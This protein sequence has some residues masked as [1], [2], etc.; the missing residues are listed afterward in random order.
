MDLVYLLVGIVVGVLIGW[1]LKAFFSE[2]GNP[3][4]VAE[5]TVQ[6][7]IY[8]TLY[9]DYQKLQATLDAKNQQCEE[10]S[11][12]LAVSEQTVEHYNEKLKTQQT[13][14]LRSQDLL[15]SELENLAN[16]L[17]EEKSVRFSEHNIHSINNLLS[18]MR[19]RFSLFESRLE[20]VHKEES[21]QRIRL[22][23]QVR[24]LAELNQQMSDDAQKLVNA[25]KGNT[26]IQ[27][28]WG[29]LVLEKVLEK[30][31]LS[32]GREYEV[33]DVHQNTE[34]NRHIPDVIIYLPENKHLII[35]SKVSLVA[36]ERFVS[37]DDDASRR[38]ALR[39]H[40][41]SLKNHIK[42]LSSKQYASLNS[43][44][45][46]DFVMLFVPIESAL[47]IALEADSELLYE[48]FKMNVILVTPSTLMATARTVSGLWKQVQQNLNAREIARL[49]GELYDHIVEFA[50]ELEQVGAKLKQ[51][52]K[53]YE[54]AVKKLQTG[55][56]SLMSGAKRLE[57]LGVS[58]QKTI[59]FHLDQIEDSDLS[60]N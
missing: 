5:Q 35:D 29:E 50:V 42:G 49:G 45:S 31:G 44:N 8:E 23:E 15:K 30:S 34:G 11:K 22:H 54:N 40:I 20:L 21:E 18:P 7:S 25:L 39:E 28:N 27:G 2:K 4:S 38:L 16:R 58:H 56:N 52:D 17:F 14:L 13:D 26:K 3:L 32:K 47:S 41:Q 24:F 60:V 36:Y 59:P 48:A 43:L 1:L 10:L 19:E 51:V 33:Q 9:K 37:S 57:S 6:Q 12:D 53:T 55:R 46:P